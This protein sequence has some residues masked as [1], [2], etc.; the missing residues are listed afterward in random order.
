MCPYVVLVLFRMF[1]KVHKSNAAP[2]KITVS[3]DDRKRKGAQRTGG[4]G[5]SAPGDPTRAT[6]AQRSPCPARLAR[7]APSF[8]RAEDTP[9]GGQPRTLADKC[10]G[11]GCPGVC[12][13]N[14]ERQVLERNLKVPM[15]RLSKFVTKCGPRK[16]ATGRWASRS[17]SYEIKNNRNRQACPRSV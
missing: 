8:L 7:S 16:P 13:W 12:V 9:S 5:L 14:K 4:G 1:E 15:G 17:I 10:G 2:E 11:R 3:T 6:Q